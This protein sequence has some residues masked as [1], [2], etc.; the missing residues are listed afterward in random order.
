MESEIST[1]KPREREGSQDLLMQTVSERGGDVWL[2]SEQHK[3]FENSLG[4][5]KH[6]GG[7]LF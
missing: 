7:P 3:W 5:R 1:A 2:I 4:T 6:H